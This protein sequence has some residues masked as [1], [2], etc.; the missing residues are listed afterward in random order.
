MGSTPHTPTHSFHGTLE[1]EHH[2]FPWLHAR[3]HRDQSEE[4]KAAGQVHPCPTYTGFK[5]VEQKGD[6]LPISEVRKEARIRLTLQENHTYRP[7]ENHNVSRDI[8]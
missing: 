8:L 1:I 5:L 6:K 7:H 4:A 3:E 2:W